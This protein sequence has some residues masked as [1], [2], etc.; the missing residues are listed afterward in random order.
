MARPQSRAGAPAPGID[1]LVD[2]A[3]DLDP[4]GDA[5]DVGAAQLE[6][7]ALAQADERGEHDEQPQPLGHR[8]DDDR[9][10]V[11]GC[12]HG[13]PLHRRAS[14][15]ADLRRRAVDQLLLLGRLEDRAQQPVR[16]GVGRRG[17][18]VERAPPRLDLGESHVA[19]RHLG[20]VRQ[21]PVRQQSLVVARPWSGAGRAR[22]RSARRTSSTVLYAASR[23]RRG[24]GDLAVPRA[25]STRRGRSATARRPARPRR[26]S[27]CRRCASSGCR[28]ASRTAPG[29]TR[30]VAPTRRSTSPNPRRRAIPQTLRLLR[31][32]ASLALS[33]APPTPCFRGRAVG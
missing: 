26:P 4:A 10:L 29:R 15:A 9:D 11:E 33:D 5:V 28:P 24:L 6:Q 13:D 16:G 17:L 31:G 8:V 22:P 30:S 19:Q 21:D 12:R 7:L 25:A 3:G 14:G 27:W 23:A 1:V 32:D 18:R 2:L 20:E